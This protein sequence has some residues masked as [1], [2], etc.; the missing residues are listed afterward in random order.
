MNRFD[1]VNKSDE[2]VKALADENVGAAILEYGF[3]L[4]DKEKYEEAFVYFRKSKERGNTFALERMITIAY[5]YAPNIISDKELFNL[6]KERHLKGV[7]Y[8]TYILAYLYKNGRGVK[9][10]LKKYAEYLLMCANDGSSTATIEMAECYEKG[11]GVA[12]DLRKA[13]DLY[14]NYIDEHC[15]K[16]TTCEYKVALYML[17]EL[18]GQKK[19]MEQIEWHLRYAATR[20]NKEA[21]KLYIELFGKDPNK[22]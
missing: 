20:Y 10:N 7:S 9:K 1:L 15:K 11:I 16:D 13:F 4:E 14:Y 3:R 6:A 18:A 8:Y 2:E 5:Y 22:E 19:D 17:N 12:K 21:L